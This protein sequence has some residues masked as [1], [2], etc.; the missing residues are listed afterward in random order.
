MLK[1]SISFCVICYFGKSVYAH[2]G[3]YSVITILNLVYLI[4][5]FLVA[6]LYIKC[7]FAH[8][9]RKHYSSVRYS[10]FVI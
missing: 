4:G 3:L 9:M 1:L 7:D 6:F 2:S 5:L 8:N 10:D